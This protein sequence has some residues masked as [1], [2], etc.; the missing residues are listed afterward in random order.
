M[1]TFRKPIHDRPQ[2]WL[3]ASLFLGLC[4]P[5]WGADIGLEVVGSWPLFPPEPAQAVV[6]SGSDTCVAA[7]ADGLR[8]I[9]IAD[10]A[11]PVGVGSMLTAPTGLCN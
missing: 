7:F 2:A 8:V 10:P 5:L 9:G 11:H 4:G 6:V 3:A 1:N